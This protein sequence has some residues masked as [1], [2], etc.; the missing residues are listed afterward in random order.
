VRFSNKTRNRFIMNNRI[1]SSLFSRL[2]LSYLLL[3]FLTLFAASVATAQVPSYVPTNGL[4]GWWPFNGNA[5]DESGNGNNGTVNGATLANDRFGI[6]NRAYSFNGSTNFI[7]VVNSS[8]AAFGM[9]SFSV[10]VWFKSDAVG[11]PFDGGFFVRYDNCVTQSGWGVGFGTYKVL[12]IEFPSNRVGNVAQSPLAYNDNQW[13]LATFVRDVSQMKDLIYVDGVIK[14][15]QTYTSINNLSNTGSP[16]RFGSCGGYQFFK[17][18]LDDIAIWSRALSNCEIWNLYNTATVQIS[19]N[20]MYTSAFCDGQNTL[21]E[22]NFVTG[23]TYQW[24]NGTTAISGANSSS[25][26]AT[27][28]GNYSVNYTTPGGCALTTNQIQVDAIPNLEFFPDSDM[29][30]YG[31]SDLTS[32]IVTCTQP[33]GYVLFNTDCNDTNASI[34]PSSIELC[35]SID[36]DCD[37]LIDNGLIFTTYYSDNDYDGF[38]INPE[39]SSCTELGLGF[40]ENNFDCNDNNSNQ[41]SLAIEIC[42]NEDDDCNGMVDNGV[43]FNN[44]YG[45][46]DSDGFGSGTAFSSCADLGFGFVLNNE[47]CNNANSQIFP[48]ASEICNNIDDN[49]DTQIDEGLVFQDFYQD[50][51][52]DGFGAGSATNSC[53]AL[54]AGFV[55]NYTDCNDA[56]ATINP[57]AEEI[58]ANGIDENCDGQID[59]SIEE[60]SN[61]LILYPNPATTELNLQTTTELIGSDLIIFDALG[62]VVLRDKILSTNQNISMINLSNGNYIL[63][64]GAMNKVF[65]ISK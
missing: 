55:N 34:N 42:N 62:K 22:A 18:T 19:L 49:C 5:N 63:R 46:I 51:D 59:N 28:S 54:G 65:T 36:E 6:L 14:N 56:N 37:G 12:G 43:S 40:S 23:Y 57:N 27:T 24:Y 1:F 25:H 21:L 45:D 31:S 50:I 60:L 11:A 53:V 2:P 8:I 48:G 61:Q 33:N 44:Y 20:S 39:I 47:D 3:P 10:S 38:G 26:F 32:A 35:N 52:A 17:G 7:N 4:V 15:Q 64:V 41:N 9:Q 13:H 30:T 16:L 29:D 58:G